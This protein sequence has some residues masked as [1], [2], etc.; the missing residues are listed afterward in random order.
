MLRQMGH[1][2]CHRPR[3]AHV[4][5]NNYRACHL[6]ESVAEFPYGEKLAAL[7]Q[8]YGLRSVTFTPLTFGVATLYIGVK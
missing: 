5:E 4:A 8:E 6:P 3:C 1:L 7:M 2:Y